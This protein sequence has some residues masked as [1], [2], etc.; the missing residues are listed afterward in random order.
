[1]EIFPILMWRWL[2]DYSFIKT[3]RTSCTPQR[4]TS[5]VHKLYLN[6]PDLKYYIRLVLY[7]CI[8]I[9]SL[10]FYRETS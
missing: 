2:H 6:K 10:S 7:L 4:L 3:H 9:Y 5:A 1:M 8:C